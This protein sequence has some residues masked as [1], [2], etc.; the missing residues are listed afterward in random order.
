MHVVDLEKGDFIKEEN[1][2]IT[3]NIKRFILFNPFALPSTQICK[4]VF[5]FHYAYKKIA[6]WFHQDFLGKD[7]AKRNYLIIN[8]LI[9]NARK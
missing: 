7:P 8:V 1:E 9:V 2:S 6:Y 4:R 5:L 3:K